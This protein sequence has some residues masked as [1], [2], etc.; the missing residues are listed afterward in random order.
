MKRFN[1]FGIFILAC[2][3]SCQNRNPPDGI[4][5]VVEEPKLLS[6]EHVYWL[7]K[8]DEPEPLPWIDT[9]AMRIEDGTES[10]NLLWTGTEENPF[11]LR[12]GDR[13]RLNPTAL[14]GAY[15]DDHGGYF[16]SHSHVLKITE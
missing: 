4:W 9:Y 2:F 12:L 14:A 8:G 5:I 6:S 15:S 13:F 3:A 7:P 10:F 1:L 11:D 16:V